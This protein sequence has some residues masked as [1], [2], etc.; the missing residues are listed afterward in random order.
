MRSFDKI[1]SEPENF[2]FFFVARWLERAH[3]P[4]DEGQA[5]GVSGHATRRFTRIC[6]ICRRSATSTPV[7]K[8]PRRFMARRGQYTAHPGTGLGNGA[9]QRA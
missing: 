4:K 2:D 8:V 3:R 1:Y 6:E 9:Q 7:A 5:T